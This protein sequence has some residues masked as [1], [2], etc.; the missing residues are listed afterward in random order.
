MKRKAVLPALTFLAF[1]SLSFLASCSPFSDIV[2]IHMTSSERI[3][4]Y[5]G[6]FSYEGIGV[7]IEYQGG[8]TQEIPL[9]ED[10]VSEVERMKF[11]KMGQQSVEVVYRNR[12][13]TTMPIEVVFNQFNESYALNG[14]ECVFDGQPHVV[15]LNHE[16]PEGA[17]ITYPYGNIFTNAGSYEVVGVLSKNGYAS[18]TLSTTLT[19]TP[20]QRPVDQILFQDA[21]VI[22]NG[23]IQELK[24]QNVPEEIEVR[25]SAYD[26]K[27][28]KPAKVINA[29]EYKIVAQFVDTNTNYQKI[30]PKEAVLTVKKAKYDVTGVT[31]EDASKAYDG[32]GYEP[33]I[34]GKENL[35]DGINPVFHFEDDEG[36]V[37]TDVSNVGTYTMVAEFEGGD[38]ANYERIEPMKAKLTVTKR[39]IKISDKVFLKDKTVNFDET[40][41][42]SLELTGN[43]PETVNVEFINNE[44]VYAGEY[45]V[46]AKF[47]AKSPNETVDISE[48]SAYLIINRVRRSVRVYN[49]ATE[50][51]DLPFTADNLVVE[52]TGKD[53]IVMVKGL[54]ETVF[55]VT[56]IGLY[57]LL[58]N[59]LVKP[60]DLVAGVTYKYVVEFE[61][62]DPNVNASVIL[63]Q[64]SDNFTYVEA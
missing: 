14:Y 3:P 5:Y 38:W 51:Y 46:T 22:Y 24:A 29:G 26:A 9:T 28:G 16:L 58:T 41:V 19:I 23:E 37:I 42:R 43:L 35:P 20:A 18:K 60:A 54:D 39:E 32:A 12:F 15:T 59:E 47:S 13:K 30:D 33:K 17:T 49:S 63:S 53:R 1:G 6:N 36:H 45:K 27:T 62:V 50:A 55:K 44:Q 7:T 52:G 57:S 21:H 31:F 2:G 48:L 61:Y 25:Y 4:V 34:K 8:S 56:S 40:Q 11:F 64:E 10:M